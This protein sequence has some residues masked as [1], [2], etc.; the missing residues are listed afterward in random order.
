MSWT[1]DEIRA[2]A[3]RLGLADLDAAALERLRAQTESLEQTVARIPRWRAKEVE[4][5]AILA[6]PGARRCPTA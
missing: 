3:A 2:M 1:H 5:A 6:I 4:P